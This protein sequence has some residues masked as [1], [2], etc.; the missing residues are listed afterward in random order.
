MLKR[1]SR[2]FVRHAR[3]KQSHSSHFWSK[4]QENKVLS[5]KDR[6]SSCFFDC[7]TLT[8][9]PLQGRPS[10]HR[11]WLRHSSFRFVRL[12]ERSW[13]TEQNLKPRHT[14]L[15]QFG[16]FHWASHRLADS[17][18][19]RSQ[20]CSWTRRKST[21]PTKSQRLDVVSKHEEIPETLA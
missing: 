16:P 17:L 13:R 14:H 1:H 2:V 6:Y 18:Q 10:P 7:S 12:R 4:S 20:V 19:L 11:F 15:R 8:E 3:G 9:R 21:C 5:R